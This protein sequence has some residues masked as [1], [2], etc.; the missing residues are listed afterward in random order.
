LS[1]I[2]KIAKKK[3]FISKVLGIGILVPLY[4]L[5]KAFFNGE[6][7]DDNGEIEYGLLDNFIFTISISIILYSACSYIS[8]ECEKR[9]P[10]RVNAKK[11]FIIQF[12]VTVLVVIV[13]AIAFTYLYNYVLRSC[14]LDQVL[15]SLFDVIIIS[16]IVSIIATSIGEAAFLLNQW[17]KALFDAERLKQENLQSQF[18]ALKNQV[19]PHFL[20]NSLNTLATI[21]PEDPNQAVEF[22]QK[23]SS[24]YRYLLQYKDDETVELKTELDCIE[25]YFFLQKIRFGDNLQVKINVPKEYHS[26]LI[27]P[28]TLQILVENA[29]KHNIISKQKP[30]EVDIYVDDVGML[31]TRNNLQKKKSVESSTKIGL[32]NLVN[33]YGYIYNKTIDIFETEKDF[34]VKVPLG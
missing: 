28:L 24:V 16:V 6:L 12:V 3:G 22:V 25:A 23:L 32:Q 18:A 7:P 31:V 26:K 27:P 21:I 11:R 34:L 1:L 30:L 20:F 4:F 8:R 15:A 13:L 33:R 29:I 5:T 17:Q 14:T 2:N 19:N 10:W 9:F